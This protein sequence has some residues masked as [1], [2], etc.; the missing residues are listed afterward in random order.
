MARRLCEIIDSAEDQ[1]LVGHAQRGDEALRRAAVLNPDVVLM[2]IE[3]EYRDAGIHAAR[4]I[5][6]SLPT[7]RI[8]ALTV[9]DDDDLVYSAFHAGFVDYILKGAEPARIQ[10]TIR[11]AFHNRVPIRSEIAEKL[12]KEFQRLK[13]SEQHFTEILTMI[14]QLTP[15]EVALLELLNSGRTREAIARER[16]VELSTVKS[17]IRGLLHKF[18]KRRT[19]NLLA[20]LNEIGFFAVLRDVS[21]AIRK[22]R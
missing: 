21:T 11:S 18:E 2:D 22:D 1:E 12:R 15:A 16:F 8:I 3:L 4:G 19:R 17:Q 7:T 6:E 9:Y 14:L 10:E 13:T 20:W 5:V